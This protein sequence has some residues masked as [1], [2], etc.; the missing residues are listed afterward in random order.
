MT[1]IHFQIFEDASKYTLDPF[2]KDLFLSC[3][4]NK[5]PPGLKYDSTK[6]VLL[7]KTRGKAETVAIS[8]DPVEVFR[9]TMNVFKNKLKFSSPREIQRRE[10]VLE[11]E[12]Q[13]RTAAADNTEWSKVKPRQFREQL[14][15]SYVNDLRKKHNLTS[16]E[17]QQL[18]S[19]IQIGLQFHAIPSTDI[20]LRDGRIKKI[21]CLKFDRESHSF[22]VPPLNTSHVKPDKTTNVN[23][24]YSLLDRFVKEY[25]ACNLSFK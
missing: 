5:F 3:A 17:A 13:K 21:R 2:W 8:D 12:K 18:V 10:D 15:L 24:L 22:R 1:I 4:T 19:I 16:K 7:V 20:I 14:I 9:I 23:R 6:K 25:S 11:E